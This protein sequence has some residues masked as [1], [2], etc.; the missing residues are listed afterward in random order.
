MLEENNRARRFYERCGFLKEADVIE[1]NPPFALYIYETGRFKRMNYFSWQTI[2][3]IKERF[4]KEIS[5]YDIVRYKKSND[6]EIFILNDSLVLFIYIEERRVM[7]LGED[8][9]KPYYSLFIE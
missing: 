8:Y 6:E 5:N 9:G 4:Q 3:R 7:T 2:M 1:D